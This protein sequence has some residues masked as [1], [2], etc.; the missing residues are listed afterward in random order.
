[1]VEA[2]CVFLVL[3][4]LTGASALQRSSPADESPARETDAARLERLSFIKRCFA[5]FE[6]SADGSGLPAAGEVPVLRYSNPIRNFFSDGA[7]FLWLDGKR[8]AAAGTISIRGA[9]DVWWEFSS[10]SER[11]LRCV[12][13]G[14]AVWTPESGNLVREPLADAPAPASSPQRRLLQMRRAARRFSVAMLEGEDRRDETSML[15][16]LPNPIYE[17]SDEAAGTGGALFAFSETTDPEALLL[18]E[19]AGEAAAD[20]P[21]WRFSVARMTSRPLS[22]RCDD[23]EVLSLKGYWANSRS[24]ADAYASGPLGMYEPPGNT[25]GGD[26]AP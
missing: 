3:A 26:A 8:P 4:V 21:S 22:I 14:R 25:A 12:R 5:E 9:G 10:F 6:L 20:K 23:R 16:L 18:L 15:R 13:E 2:R 1:M 17:W 19:L 24:P 7:T 11:P